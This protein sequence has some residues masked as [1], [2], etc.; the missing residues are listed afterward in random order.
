[1]F[2]V[3]LLHII[4]GFHLCSPASLFSSEFGWRLIDRYIQLLN[5][6]QGLKKGM[7]KSSLIDSLLTFI[8][9]VI[10]TCEGCFIVLASLKI[11]G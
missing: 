4:S 10:L 6:G 8:M 3:D 1:M 7:Q 9:G 2:T 11:L 5:G